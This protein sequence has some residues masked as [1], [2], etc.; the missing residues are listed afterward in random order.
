M[1]DWILAYPMSLDLQSWELISYLQE[2]PVIMHQEKVLRLQ[3]FVQL[4]PQ[5]FRGFIVVS[6]VALQWMLKEDIIFTNMDI[7]HD[8]Q[9]LLFHEFTL[10]CNEFGKTS[11]QWRKQYRDTFLQIPLKS[12]MTKLQEIKSTVPIQDTQS[13]E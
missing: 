6:E 5:D 12:W 13:V 2:K 11:A 4:S 10:L 8:Q 3:S 1:V 7:F 9:R